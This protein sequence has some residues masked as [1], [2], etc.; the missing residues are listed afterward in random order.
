MKLDGNRIFIVALAALTIGVYLDH[1]G[2]LSDRKEELIQ[3]VVGLSGAGN[4][5]EHFAK[6]K[7]KEIEK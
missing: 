1:T 2:G 6:A 5:F 3:W 4:A 7:T